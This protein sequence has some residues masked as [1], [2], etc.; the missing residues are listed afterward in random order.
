MFKKKS[1]PTTGEDETKS[2]LIVDAESGSPTLFRAGRGAAWAMSFRIKPRQDPSPNR[3]PTKVVFTEADERV[4]ME[5]EELLNPTIDE[6]AWNSPWYMERATSKEV[7]LSLNNKADGA[8]V[9]RD[10]TSEVN[11]FALSYRFLGATHH[12]VIHNNDNQLVLANGTITFSCLSDLVY[13]Y[14]QRWVENDPIQCALNPKELEVLSVDDPPT[15]PPITHTASKVRWSHGAV[16]S[17]LKQ[18]KVSE[19]TL[20][21]FEPRKELEGPQLLDLTSDN[22]NDWQ[23]ESQDIEMILGAI[24]SIKERISGDTSPRASEQEENE[25]VK[26]TPKPAATPVSKAEE[27]AFEFPAPGAA[28]VDPSDPLLP[29]DPAYLRLGPA[30]E[31]AYGVPSPR[32]PPRSTHILIRSASRSPA[33]STPAS[34]V[35]P[36]RIRGD[37]VSALNTTRPPPPMPPTKRALPESVRKPLRSCLRQATQDA[38]SPRSV[39]F[40]EKSIERA[41]KQL[42]AMRGIYARI[43]AAAAQASY[44]LGTVMRNVASE[45]LRNAPDGVFVIFDSLSSNTCLYLLHILEG[46]LVHSIIEDSPNGLHFKKSQ[47]M[48]A[49]LSELVTFYGTKIDANVPNMLDLELTLR[50]LAGADSIFAAPGDLDKKASSRKSVVLETPS[51]LRKDLTEEDA[52]E[53]IEFEPMGACVTMQLL[54]LSVPSQ[55][56]NAMIA[57]LVRFLRCLSVQFALGCDL[58]CKAGQDFYVDHL[59]IRQRFPARNRLQELSHSGSARYSFQSGALSVATLSSKAPN[60]GSTD[61]SIHVHTTQI[62]FT[63]QKQQSGSSNH[64]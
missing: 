17:W 26:P 50:T 53:L 63:C 36:A 20:K 24:H 23:L 10:S 32:L 38:R 11:G 15:E 1:I 43:D 33:T 45:R 42:R 31:P 28:P 39:I 14:S 12:T 16:L 13:H 30:P 37:S 47:H 56:V 52:V 60:P 51:W 21:F 59:R 40:D 44:Y 64:S 9:I 46:Q 54:L 25:E 19:H 49:T 62:G 18:L 8:F 6:T 29:S 4:E 57:R 2:Q 61:I 58:G 41:Q 55:L 35:A 22:L 27:T 48:F 5:D 3:R 34:P 7:C